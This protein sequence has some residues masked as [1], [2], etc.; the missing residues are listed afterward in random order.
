MIPERGIGCHRTG[1]AKS[2]FDMVT[3]KR[4]RLWQQLQGLNPQT[5]E[6]INQWGCADQFANMLRIENSQQQRQTAAAVESF[7]NE[8]VNVNGV[9][10]IRMSLANRAPLQ[11][12][13][14]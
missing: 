1:F 9:T 6:Q 13:P 4:C 10:A 7:R 2:C 14:D 11:L 8:M 5:G 3:K 12:P